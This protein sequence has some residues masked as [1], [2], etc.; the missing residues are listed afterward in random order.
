MVVHKTIFGQQKDNL[1][2][3][4]KNNNKAIRWINN[5]ANLKNY[6]NLNCDVFTLL[7]E[8]RSQGCTAK[9]AYNVAVA[10]FMSL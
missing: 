8:F 4:K 10:C 5:I 7:T 6:L 1:L 2:F 3:N 9:D